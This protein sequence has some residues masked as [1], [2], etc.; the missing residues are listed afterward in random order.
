MR[1]AIRK[2]KKGGRLGKTALNLYTY[3]V[4]NIVIVGNKEIR[5]KIQDIEKNFNLVLVFTEPKDLEESIN[6]NTI[7]VIIDEKEVKSKLKQYVMAVLGAYKMLPI[8]YL[9]RSVKRHNFYKDFYEQGLQGIIKWPSEA[10]VLHNLI[11]ESLKPHPKAVGKSK[12]DARMADLI[13]SHLILNGNYKGIRVKVIEGFAFLEGRVRSLYD[14]RL[15]ERESSK[16]L[17]VKKVISKNIK[18]KDFK[19]VTDKELERKIK[20][21]IG[22]ILGSK[23]RSLSVKVRNKIVTLMGAASYL[24]DVLDIEKFAMKQAGVKEIVRLVKY[25][26]SLVLKNTKRAKFLEQKIKKLFDGV[27]HVSISIYGEL[28]EVSGMVKIKADKAL[29]ERYLLQVLPVKKIVNKI[30]VKD[31]Y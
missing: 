24:G 22:N 16:V 25:Q 19:K 6:A 15:I 9:S 3:K 28:A 27:K 31:H 17:G 18:I 13:K 21:Y 20:M 4:P 23:K 1:T 2:N 7:A 29:V 10:K 8:F 11:I 12:G 26:P 14:K 5:K 30:F